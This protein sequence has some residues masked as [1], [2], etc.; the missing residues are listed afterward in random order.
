MKLQC[1]QLPPPTTS[2]SSSNNSNSSR[3]RPPSPQQPQPRGQAAL[4]Q[5]KLPC[6]TKHS[7]LNSPLNHHRYT[8]VMS[9]RSAVLD[10]RYFIIM[11]LL[12]LF[13]YCV[14]ECPDT[15]VFLILIINGLHELWHLYILPV[16]R[17][18]RSIWRVRSTKR[19]KQHWSC[20]RATVAAAE[21][22]ALPVAHRISYAVNSVTSP[23]LELMPTPLTS[24]EPNTRRYMTQTLISAH[25]NLLSAWLL[26]ALFLNAYDSGSP[27]QRGPLRHSLLQYPVESSLKGNGCHI[28]TCI[29]DYVMPRCN[30]SKCDVRGCYID[31]MCLVSNL[32]LFL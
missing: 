25:N 11:H 19:R 4:L 31:Y 3:N 8:T 6:R 26:A 16:F 1:I 20:H 2:S 18:I 14:T 17:P 9:A 24:E 32:I 5:R 23:V 13:V 7:N 28:S 12:L 29:L 30:K 27:L 22:G 15:S 10:P 21:A